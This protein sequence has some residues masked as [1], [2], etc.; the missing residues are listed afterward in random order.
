MR[1]LIGWAAILLGAAIVEPALLA[2]ILLVPAWAWWIRTRIGGLS[3]DGHG[4]GIEI[5]E[6]GLLLAAACLA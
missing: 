4:A 2:T 5:V 6:T 1:D 3:G